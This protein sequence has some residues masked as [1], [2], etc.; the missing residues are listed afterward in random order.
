MI[1]KTPLLFLFL[2]V[3]L[4]INFLHFTPHNSQPKSISVFEIFN[5]NTI[6][7]V[8]I[9]NT[10]TNKTWHLSNKGLSKL[11]IILKKSTAVKNAV[12]LKPGHLNIAFTFKNKI[13]RYFYMYSHGI[14]NDTQIYASRT[15]FPFSIELSQ[16]VDWDKLK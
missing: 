4:P 15:D 9:T 12:F 13:T 14:Y 7:D 2:T 5:V 16:G 10:Y 6:T 11:K 1:L 8:E 3:Y